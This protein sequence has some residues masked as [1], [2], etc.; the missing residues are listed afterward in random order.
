VKVLKRTAFASIALSLACVYALAQDAAPAKH[1]AA[2]QAR[3]RAKPELSDVK[4]EAVPDKNAPA[5]H[6]VFGAGPEVAA[7]QAAEN[8]ARRKDSPGSPAKATPDGQAA[9][10]AQKAPEAKSGGSAAPT[11]AIG[12]FQVAPS[13]TDSSSASIQTGTHGKAPR[14]R[15]HGEVYGAG[16]GV[17]RDAGGAVGASSKSGKTSVYVQSDQTRDVATPPQ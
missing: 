4:P 1:A 16:G 13:G 14:E 8:L 15:V 12:E 5:L 6:G 7:R 9:R 2:S 17:G 11:G 10:L 3:E